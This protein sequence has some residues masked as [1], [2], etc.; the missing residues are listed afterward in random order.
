LQSSRG[1]Q[2]S[3]HIIHL[4]DLS[5]DD[6][7]RM[8][9]MVTD[10]GGQVDFRVVDASL[11]APFPSKGPAEGN[12]ISWARLLIPDA[13]FD[14]QRIIFLDADTFVARSLQPL[15]DQ[16]VAAPLA[17][18]ANV[19]EPSMRGHVRSLGINGLGSYFNAGV[20]LM[21]L[22]LIRTEGLLTRA[23]RTTHEGF[24]L[25]WFDQDVLNI[26]F[27]GRWQEIGPEWNVQNSFLLWR[28]WALEMFDRD[29]LD[30]AL[31]IP[32]ILHFEG[33]LLCKPWHY[34]CQH[35]RRDEYRAVLA[36]T[37]WSD[38]GLKDRSI[39]TRA[40]RRLPASWRLPMYRR[41]LRWRGTLQT[42]RTTR[43][44]A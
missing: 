21:D 42:F 23:Q 33:P 11:L 27:A 43:E 22:D 15:W 37:P 31:R 26:V 18:V 39:G 10:H 19:V 16:P 30:E 8:L 24:D 36:Q 41:L 44:A 7:S 32:G 12:H 28:P 38:V 3:F 25:R 9:S 34:L 13:L 1:E 14:V 5:T 20:L 35:P 17:A 40:I 29:S 4:G 6:Q 2:L